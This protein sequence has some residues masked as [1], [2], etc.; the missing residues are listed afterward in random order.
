MQACNWRIKCRENQDMLEV[1]NN[2]I[3]K[4][5]VFLFSIQVSASKIAFPVKG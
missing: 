3:V 1:P 2:S 4:L 5:V